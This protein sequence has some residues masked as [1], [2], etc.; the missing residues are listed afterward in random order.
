ML[1]NVRPAERFQQDSQ[2][3]NTRGMKDEGGVRPGGGVRGRI[4]EKEKEEKAREEEEVE[5]GEWG[6]R[7]WTEGYQK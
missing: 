6:G 1:R 3:S 2:E 4:G 5:K 7:T